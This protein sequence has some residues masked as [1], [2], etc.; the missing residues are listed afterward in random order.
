MMENGKQ[1]HS[2]PVY[3]EGPLSSD[4]LQDLL[5]TC[6]ATLFVTNLE[7]ASNRMWR[8][9]TCVV[10]EVVIVEISLLNRLF[11]LIY[12]IKMLIQLPVL[13]SIPNILL[14]FYAVSGLRLYLDSGQIFLSLKNITAV[15]DLDLY[16][17]RSYLL[18]IFVYRIFQKYFIPSHRHISFLVISNRF[19]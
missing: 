12:T 1:L 2:I 15:S 18:E 5:C 10:S 7:D 8:D 11:Q 3:F 19:K 9:Q 14:V 6:K 13:I 16:G 4:I 17:A